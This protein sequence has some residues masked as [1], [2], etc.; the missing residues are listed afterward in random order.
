MSRLII[1]SS[2]IYR[3]YVAAKFKKYGEYSVIRCTDISNFEANMAGLEATDK[4]VIISVIENF[5]E[6]AG[7]GIESQ[8]EKEAAIESAMIE[9]IRIIKEAATRLSGS[10]M[11]IIEPI[12]RPS[13]DW[14]EASYD[15]IRKFV[16]EGTKKLNLDNITTIGAI[17]RASQIFN[18]DGVHLTEDA[19][20][21]FLESILSHAKS[22]MNAK[23][24][25]VDDNE[26]EEMEEDFRSE[27]PSRSGSGK[28]TFEVSWKIQLIEDEARFR[29]S[30]DDLLFARVREE[31]DTMSN[32]NKE[33]RVVIT[34]I[35]TSVVAPVDQEERKVWLRS[36]VES[37]FKKIS[38]DF[39]GKILFIN[40]GRSNG[41][42]IPMAEVRLDSIASAVAIRKAFADK[43]KAGEDFGRLFLANC[44]GLATRV[45]VDIMK[46]LAK[47][48][49]VNSDTAFVVAFTSRPMLH[50]R[51]VPPTGQPKTMTYTFSDAVARFGGRLQA[52]DLEEA[53]RRAGN[54]FRGQMSQHFVVLHDLYGAHPGPNPNPRKRGREEWE[55]ARGSRS[56]GRGDGRGGRGD[57]RGFGKGRGYKGAR[58]H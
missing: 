27:G 26:E 20:E 24:Y 49:M 11:I 33:D 32:K 51:S 40:Q 55:P 4:E 8:D 10:R 16:A 52:G 7:R 15:E 22:F 23:T 13:L 41:K 29:R 14:Y 56:G 34:G 35:T 2:N 3:N 47:R 43:K 38:P 42:L 19:G 17:S 28:G 25:T 36:T 50:I 30:N 58:F 6:K 57:G 46:A 48:C 1:G 45:R 39:T 37:I 21:V 9:Y 44:V 31:L 12:L 53:Y 54:N 18:K 5:I